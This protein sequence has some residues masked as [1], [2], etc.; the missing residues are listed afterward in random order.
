MKPFIAYIDKFCTGRSEARA[1][2]EERDA[3]VMNHILFDRLPQRKLLNSHPK[4]L[5][6]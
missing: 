3:V 1:R 4:E 6:A 5:S 2:S